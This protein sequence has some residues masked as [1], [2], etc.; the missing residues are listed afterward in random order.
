ME[1]VISDIWDINLIILL[2]GG[3]HWHT[4]PS[5]E[6]YSTDFQICPNFKQIKNTDD[7]F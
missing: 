2:A 3:L 4:E 1:L 5:A 7:P 6:I